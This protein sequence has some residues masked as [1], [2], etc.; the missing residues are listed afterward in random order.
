MFTIHRG[1][2]AARTTLPVELL[3]LVSAAMPELLEVRLC[4]VDFMDN[5]DE[6]VAADA[7]DVVEVWRTIVVSTVEEETVIV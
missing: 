5:A 2:L 6:V 4:V 3:L 1:T 7:V